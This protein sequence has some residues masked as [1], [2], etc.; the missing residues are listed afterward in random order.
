ME[1]LQQ[2][3]SRLSTL[4]R[5]YLCCCVTSSPSERVF[6]T[7]VNI[8][9]RQICF[10]PEKVNTM[11]FWAKNLWLCKYDNNLTCTRT[12]AINSNIMML[13]WTI[14]LLDKFLYRPA[15][16]SDYN[17]ATSYKWHPFIW[18]VH[19]VHFVKTINAPFNMMKLT[20]WHKSN[21][22]YVAMPCLAQ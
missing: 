17:E 3:F 2:I 1:V 18:V 9:S 13:L 7:S 14:I 10:K 20:N 4:A 11:V 6:S 21:R 19:G 16:V 12:Q 8:S 5:K 22:N 15:L